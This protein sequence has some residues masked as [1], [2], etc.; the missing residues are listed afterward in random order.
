MATNT[1]VSALIRNQGD[2]IRA[3]KSSGA[4]QEQ[5]DKEIAKLQLIKKEHDKDDKP[6]FS[7]K[8]A[9][10]ARDFDPQQMAVRDQLFSTIT[11]CFK[12]H[13]A[14]TIDTPVFE[15][16]DTLTGKYGEDSK[17]IYDLQ[18]QGGELLSLRYDL[19]VP[20]ARYVAMNRI[21]QIK[22]YHIAKVYRRDNPSIQKGR[23]REFYQCDFDIAGQFDPM[24][25]DSECIRVV[26]EILK[27]LNLSDFVIKVNHRLLLDAIFS[28]SGVS[29]ANFRTVCSS[30][31]KLD[32]ISWEEV[33]NELVKEK[34]I[35]QETA[36]KIGT[37]VNLSGDNS[38]LNKLQTDP[39]LSTNQNAQIAI[40]ELQLLYTYCQRLLIG[41]FVTFDM[42]LARG[43]DYYT[44]V[45]Y[46][47]VLIGG[48]KYE[49][50]SVAAG[51]RYDG[52]VG[53]FDVKNRAVPCVGVS[54]G[55][56]RLFSI[57]EQKMKGEKIRTTETEV[58][59]MSGEDG[60]LE[61]RLSCIA[62]LWEQ[63]I[64]AELFYKKSSKLLTQIQFCEKEFIPLG[65]IIAT[66]EQ[67]NGGVKIRNISTR[68]DKFVRDEDMVLEIKAFLG[69]KKCS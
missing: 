36:D 37:Y 69:N 44:G 45:I 48:H 28:I 42:S 16:K 60:F 46:E 9:K 5:I 33:R 1:D 53:M 67:K 15:L 63:N 21:K 23:Y 54:I 57:M 32:K 61:Q 64:N 50:G 6:Q 26:A 62:K 68:E 10:G 4:S 38:L 25:P 58:L 22:R 52:L 19:T 43:L 27:E 7:L 51:G 30:V 35:P 49:V 59:V 20:F 13:G 39:L 47:A 55:V 65:V 40:N 14:V 24:I 56:E 18:D 17:L 29:E 41:Q 34:H 31:D 66:E 8:C 2:V 3:L 11:S 12:R